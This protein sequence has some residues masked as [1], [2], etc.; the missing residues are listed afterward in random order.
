MDMA[1]VAAEGLLQSDDEEL[2]NHTHSKLK[3][4]KALWEETSTY[5][6][7]CHRCRSYFTH[8]LYLQSVEWFAVC[9]AGTH[10]HVHTVKLLMFDFRTLLT[11]NYCVIIIP[12]LLLSENTWI[13]T[14]LC[15]PCGIYLWSSTHLGFFSHIIH[16]TLAHNAK[17]WQEQHISDGFQFC[18][19]L[20]IK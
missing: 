2:R 5:I 17:M 3:D 1:L 19:L 14:T 10:S 13:H 11:C 12:L 18:L 20:Q 9:P 7:H 8:P 15:F 16:F 6:I 4:L